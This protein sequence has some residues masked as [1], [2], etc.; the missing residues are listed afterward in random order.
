VWRLLIFQYGDLD[1]ES[2]AGEGV[3]KT[4]RGGSGTEAAAGAS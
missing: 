3:A 1:A 4:E 2:I